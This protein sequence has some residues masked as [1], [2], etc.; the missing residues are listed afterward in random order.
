MTALLSTMMSTYQI[1]G[2]DSNSDAIEKSE[3]H[4][5]FDYLLTDESTFTSVSASSTDVGASIT[6]TLDLETLSTYAGASGDVLIV[7]LPYDYYIETDS[8]VSATCDSGTTNTDGVFLDDRRTI[9]FE[10]FDS[11]QC[12]ISGGTPSFEISNLAI[13]SGFAST[14]TFGQY[15]VALLSSE[16]SDWYDT[17]FVAIA[18]YKDANSH[19]GT[20]ETYN[21]LTTSINSFTTSTTVWD[22]QITDAGLAGVQPNLDTS[23]EIAFE[24]KMGSYSVDLSRSDLHLDLSTINSTY[25]MTSATVAIYDGTEIMDMTNNMLIE[26]TDIYIYTNTHDSGVDDLF[27]SK[28]YCQGGTNGELC[29]S[30]DVF[31][32]VLSGLSSI[33]STVVNT[34]V[35]D[36]FAFIDDS[37]SQT[38]TGEVWAPTLEWANEF[39]YIYSYE[40]STETHSFE[41]F[42]YGTISEGMSFEVVFIDS[43]IPT[44][45]IEDIS[46]FTFTTGSSAIESVTVTT[47]SLKFTVA[48]GEYLNN[49]AFTVNDLIDFDSYMKLQLEELHIYDVDDT[50]VDFISEVEMEDALQYATFTDYIEDV[51]MD[52]STVT[53]NTADVEITL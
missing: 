26:G 5:W 29:N 10:G 30:D 17:E 31:T 50:V 23:T 27:A 40:E 51:E 38:M 43:E 12:S 2:Y 21:S 3:E 33:S 18:L 47:T 16:D 9:A 7:Q 46:D 1:V 41:F 45:T 6:L 14:L 24:I 8:T 37:G 32:V 28:F 36:T 20:A 15:I 53:D 49:L 39:S 25:D 48:S 11:S 52:V 19:D 44:N 4:N 35:T 34:V 42:L 22:Q 13:N